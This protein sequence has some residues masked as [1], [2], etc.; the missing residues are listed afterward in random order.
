VAGLSRK[1]GQR[2]PSGIL[3]EVPSKR[4]RADETE[5]HPSTIAQVVSYPHFT[6]T[7]MAENRIIPRVALGDRVRDKVTGLEGVATSRTE[8]MYGCLRIGVIPRGE[9][10]EGGEKKGFVADEPQLEILEKA[11]IK[12]EE[13]PVKTATGAA[14]THGDRDM[15]DAGYSVPAR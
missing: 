8:F 1:G 13:D 6:H 7:T 14:R 3:V 11:A 4:A 12:I 5:Q 2:G 15:P 10:K 9:S